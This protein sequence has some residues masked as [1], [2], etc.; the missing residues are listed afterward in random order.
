MTMRHNSVNCYLTKKRLVNKFNLE[1]PN[2]IPSLKKISL[3]FSNKTHE[4]GAV[5]GSTLALNL[6]TGANSQINRPKTSA[7]GSFGRKKETP[8][9]NSLPLSRHKMNQFI[10]KIRL[11]VTPKYSA[12]SKNN[13]KLPTKTFSFTL[14]N[15]NLQSLED[16]TQNK[17]L[18][19][20]LPP[21]NVSLIFGKKADFLEKRVILS[22]FCL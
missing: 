5:A 13:Q 22:L 21:L 18:I 6:L 8:S 12:P 9:S 10:N 19:K 2:K 20:K 14:T 4:L 16:I 3:N 17:A 1:H 15:E 11:E 7:G